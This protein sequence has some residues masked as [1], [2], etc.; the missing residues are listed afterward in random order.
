MTNLSLRLLCQRRLFYLL[1]LHYQF[2]FVIFNIKLVNYSLLRKWT[3][4]IFLAISS[5]FIFWITILAIPIF[6]IFK[7]LRY[8]LL[9]RMIPMII[10]RFINF[11]RSKIFNSPSFIR[12][13]HFKKSFFLIDS[14][15]LI[16]LWISVENFS[17]LKINVNFRWE[18]S[19]WI[20]ILMTE[21]NGLSSRIIVRL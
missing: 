16:K 15:F 8:F 5:P 18:R 7:S 1:I 2:R 11:L 21:V 6:I 4:T 13:W 10:I 9:S 20:S 14:W 12:N 3:L 17:L 19:F